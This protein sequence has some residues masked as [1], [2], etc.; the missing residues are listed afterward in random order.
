MRTKV[1]FPGV[2]NSQKI[3]VIVDGVGFYTR[4]CEIPNICTTKH[5]VAVES[6]LVSLSESIK[7]GDN[8]TGYGSHVEVILDG[9][10]T[11]VPVQVDI[12]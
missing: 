1:M 3:R 2:K 10:S 9:A 12:V 6:A 5:M 7:K 11:M 8:I 4:V